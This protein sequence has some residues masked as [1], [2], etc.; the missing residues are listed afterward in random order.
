MGF[1]PFVL[2]PMYL[3]DRTF[4]TEMASPTSNNIRN[5]A[6]RQRKEAALQDS[7][8][9]SFPIKKLLGPQGS[10]HRKFRDFFDTTDT[11]YVRAI[12]PLWDAPMLPSPMLGDPSILGPF[13]PHTALDKDGYGLNTFLHPSPRPLVGTSKVIS[14]KKDLDGLEA[15]EDFSINVVVATQSGNPRFAEN[16][17]L[18]WMGQ[19]ETRTTL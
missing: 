7:L 15:Q 5:L 14:F 1:P 6:I 18:F 10:Q 2:R 16:Q 11:H 4:S 13:V 8:P 17:C 19:M 12:S 9:P 3:L